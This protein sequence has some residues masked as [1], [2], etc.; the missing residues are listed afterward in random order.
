MCARKALKAVR[1][2]TIQGRGLRLQ[3]SQRQRIPFR[4]MVCLYLSYCESCVTCGLSP[5]DISEEAVFEPRH[6]ATT[7]ASGCPT[8]T[9]LTHARRRSTAPA[10]PQL[11]WS[12]RTVRTAAANMAK[13]CR[14]PHRHKGTDDPRHQSRAEMVVLQRCRC[15]QGILHL[16]RLGHRKKTTFR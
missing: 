9:A 13:G 5:K 6:S 12:R 7:G 10:A 8:A 16:R 15:C 11:V 14:K 3:V 2:I 1:S 4:L